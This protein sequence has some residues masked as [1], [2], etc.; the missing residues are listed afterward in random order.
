MELSKK[1][2]RMKICLNLNVKKTSDENVQADDTENV[3]IFNAYTPK[4]DHII[5]EGAQLFKP[6]APVIVRMLIQTII[7]KNQSC[8]KSL[9]ATCS[10]SKPCIC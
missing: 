5:F 6:L 4:N 3:I 8:H 9:G 7:T 2:E 10:S 1:S